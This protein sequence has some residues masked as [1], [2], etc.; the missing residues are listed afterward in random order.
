MAARRGGD[1][2]RLGGMTRRLGRAIRPSG[3][4]TRPT[5]GAARRS[6]GMTLPVGEA[7]LPIG[8]TTRRL[9]RMIPPS[10]REAPPSG[11]MP[12]SLGFRV[13][14]PETRFF[15]KPADDGW[16]KRDSGAGCRPDGAGEWGG[17]GGYKDFAPDGAANNARNRQSVDL[18]DKIS[19]VT[20]KTTLLLTKSANC[21]IFSPNVNLIPILEF[22]V[23]SG[24]NQFFNGGFS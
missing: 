21:E 15:V 1:A 2:R 13:F 24:Q 23:L 14:D 11:K 12:N 3:R 5:G 9:G 10:H 6:G 22:L 20:N 4:T 19:H 17:A 7:I 18:R 16:P 8:R